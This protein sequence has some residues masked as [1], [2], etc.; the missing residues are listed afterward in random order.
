MDNTDLE[1]DPLGSLCS[2]ITEK[3]TFN[4]ASEACGQAVL[5]NRS[6]LTGQQLVENAQIEKFKCDILCNFQTG[7]ANQT[8]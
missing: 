6:V 5:S 2:K 1:L 4:I 3:V 7:A 8:L